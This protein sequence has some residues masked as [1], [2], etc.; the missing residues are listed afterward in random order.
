MSGCARMQMSWSGSD[1]QPRRSAAYRRRVQPGNSLEKRIGI[2]ATPPLTC[3]FPVFNRRRE[4]KLRVTRPRRLRSAGLLP[5]LE[6]GER[7]LDMAR[8]DVL[9]GALVLER[10]LGNHLAVGGD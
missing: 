1:H 10:D 9:G 5:V 7:L 4:R 8:E 2:H 3:I 6:L